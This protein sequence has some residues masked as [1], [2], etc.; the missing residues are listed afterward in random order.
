M[1]RSGRVYWFKFICKVF[2]I[3]KMAADKCSSEEAFCRAVDGLMDHLTHTLHTVVDD[4][5]LKLYGEFTE[6][7]RQNIDSSGTD[8]K[9]VEALFTS[10]KTKSVNVHQKCLKALEELKHKDV[11]KKLNE[12][13]ENS[14]LAVTV[15]G[16]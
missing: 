11:A 8:F 14:F 16:K 5:K 12:K 9:K 2:N 7:E 1:L 6:Q 3:N 15:A 4:L 10:L 13:M